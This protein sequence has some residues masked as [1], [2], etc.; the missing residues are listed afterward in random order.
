MIDEHREG[1]AG[2]A[3]HQIY[4]QKLPLPTHTSLATLKD[5]TLGVV[6]EMADKIIEVQGPKAFIFHTVSLTTCKK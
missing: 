2:E 5:K 6:K 3:D 1:T 4:F